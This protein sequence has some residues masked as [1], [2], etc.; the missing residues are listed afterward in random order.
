MPT[1]SIYICSYESR[2]S[3]KTKVVFCLTL[4]NINQCLQKLYLEYLSVGVHNNT[5]DDEEPPKKRSR[6]P[7]NTYNSSPQRPR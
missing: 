1:K 7:L 5:N 6:N 3:L 4:K 2:F